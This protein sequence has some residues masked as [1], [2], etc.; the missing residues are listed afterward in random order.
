LIDG[1]TKSKYITNYSIPKNNQSNIRIDEEVHGN[2]KDILELVE[3]FE[4]R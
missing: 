3:A 2:L 4:F 1:R